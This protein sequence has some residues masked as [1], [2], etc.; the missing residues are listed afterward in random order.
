MTKGGSDTSEK[1]SHW[2]QVNCSSSKG[3]FKLCI[4]TCQLGRTIL[5][6][7]F[8]YESDGQVIVYRRPGEQ[9]AQCNFLT[10][11]S[12]GGGSIMVWIG[13]SLD[14]ATELV[15]LDRGNLNAH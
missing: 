15:V 2:I 11:E 13:I 3:P 8:V 9:Y 4:R 10:K 7:S 14:V 6:Q 5:E 1:T 12:F